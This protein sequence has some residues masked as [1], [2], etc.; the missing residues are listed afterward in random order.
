M[1]RGNGEG[2]VYQRRDGRWVGSVTVEG[3]RRA[4]YGRT[5]EDA[6]AK[7]QD[8]Q[9]G[10]KKGLPAVDQ[11]ATVGTY[12]IRWLSEV[13]PRLRTTTATRYA[14]LVRGQIIPSVGRVKL[15]QLQPSDVARMMAT[16]Q[17]NGLSARTASHCRAVLRAALSDAERDGVI[18]RN[19]A[20][21]A[22]A[23]HLAPPQP[24]VLS[25]DQVLAML[26]A[27]SDP[28]L[29]RLAVVAITTGLRMGEQLGLRWAD[30]D[31]ERRC[32]HVRTALQRAAGAYS[33]SEPK[34][35][36]S[37]RVVAL[38]ESALEALREERRDQAA[39][40]LAAGGR[41]HQPIPDLCFTTSSGQPRNGTSLTHLF[42][43]ALQRAGLPQL[44]WHDL[45]AAHGA[46]LL[47]GGTDISVVSRKLGHSSV[48][49]TSRHYG[50]VA[51]SLQQ[52]A[53]DRLG[54]LLARPV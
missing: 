46:L 44:R 25:P 24:T 53:A 35:S 12:L 27:C 18:H 47:A 22:D 36:T 49:L 5:R 39:S 11:R 41:W 42:Q 10:V 26:D 1:S 8:L 52:D 40:Q 38:P 21:L 28:S 20:K 13:T 23:P 15:Y 50:G 9:Q 51:D 14:G 7:L 54:K 16:V 3:R 48:S 33:L 30:I 4:A 32:L 34:S 45:R 6:A 43:D 31:L 19:A 29:R 2:S 17:R 37:R